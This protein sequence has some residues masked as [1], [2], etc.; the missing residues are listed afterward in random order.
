MRMLNNIINFRNWQF[1]RMFW[2]WL[3]V[4]ILSILLVSINPMLLPVF[5]LLLGLGLL[6]ADQKLA[7]FV[8]YIIYLPTNGMIGRESFLMGGIGIQQVLGLFTLMA[9]LRIRV[10]NK[11]D[12]F[13]KT[14]TALLLLLLVYLVYTSFKNAYFDMHDTHWI[15]AV[16]RLINVGM[17]Y[18]PL[19]LMIRKMGN[20]TVNEW[21]QIAVFLGVL[22]MAV[23]CYLSPILPD[24]GF[25]SLGTETVGIA[26]DADEYNRFTGII[27]DGDS[28][29][30]GGFFVIACGYYLSRGKALQ[31][32]M[33]I[34]TMVGICALGVALTASRTALV[35]L[36]MIVVIFF[37]SS[38]ESRLKAQLLVGVFLFI[39]ASA[40]L[41]ETVIDRMIESGSEQLNTQTSSNR[42][43]KWI[44]YFDHFQRHP[45]TFLYGADTPLFIGFKGQFIVA[46]NFY[47]QIIYN[48][49]MFFLAGFA[50]L[51]A[52]IFKMMLRRVS[53]YR[54][55]LIVLPL[56]AVTF[57]VSDVG[58][59]IYF[60]IFFAMNI[61]KHE[62][63]ERSLSNLQQTPRWA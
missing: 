40:P 4:A 3:T 13:K 26:R 12:E 47:I 37:M 55:D 20:P 49:G 28:N 29:T 31:N 38:R 58:A 54:L 33:L 19:V 27:G 7:L 60:I 42:I 61:S 52:R 43:G 41:W 51:Y 30:L 5:F 17:L 16:K 25:Y 32:S 21:T 44:L 50:F 36:V 39:I 15:D 2:M 56:L 45:S 11:S 48:T 53:A 18:T 1:R 62:A 8:L 46:H 57:F 22:N 6:I 14:A 59:F 63:P 23:F 34:K 24:L 35:A 9:V 10:A